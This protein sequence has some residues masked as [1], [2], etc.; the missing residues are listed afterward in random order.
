MVLS[1]PRKRAFKGVFKPTSAKCYK[2]KRSNNAITN[3]GR[4][5]RNGVVQQPDNQR[6]HQKKWHPG[7][8]LC[9]VFVLT[10]ARALREIKY[11]QSA[12][13]DESVLIPKRAF[14][15]LVREIS[16]NMK[17]EFHDNFA[18]VGVSNTHRWSGEYRWES[19]ALI[20]LQLMTE[21]VLIMVMGMT[22]D[23]FCVC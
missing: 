11:Y 16:Q 1:V 14:Q 10:V 4:R 23:S 5:G 6:T 17:S 13:M 9:I 21:H 3:P 20:A 8:T 7:S 2:P 12:V 18:G 22:Y 15:K 19:D